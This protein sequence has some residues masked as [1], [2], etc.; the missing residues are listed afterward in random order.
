MQIVGDLSPG[1]RVFVA[2]LWIS[3]SAILRN[4]SLKGYQVCGLSHN[5]KDMG[6]RSR[7]GCK[8]VCP[9]PMTEPEA[10]VGAVSWL[11]DQCEEKPFIIPTSDHYVAALDREAPRLADKLLYY[12]F[13]DGALDD[14]GSGNG[15]HGRL[16]SKR[17]T[18]E[19]AE[20]HGLA[21]PATVPVESAEQLRRF[22]RRM[23]APV[24][25]KPEHS[26]D[27]WTP[28][29]RSILG[30][31]KAVVAESERE[32]IELYDRVGPVSERL[33]AQEVIPGP[34]SN[35]IY[36]AG[37][38]A[39]DGTLRG[40]L[41]GRKLRV[42]P[43]HLGSGT[44]VKLV[45][46]PEVEKRCE[47]FL[48]A[49]GYRGLCGIEFKIDPR[50]GIAKLIEVNPRYGLWEDIG[51]PAGV[52]LAEEAL[53]SALGRETQPHRPR[54]FR[55]K[56]MHFKSDLAVSFDY[57]AEGLLGPLAWLGSFATPLTVCDLPL[58]SDWPLARHNLASMFAIAMRRLG[59]TALG[60][61][62]KADIKVPNPRKSS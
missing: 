53:L 55:R 1:T 49:L 62:A 29:A 56:W 10:W 14:C 33:I 3:G 25:L 30:H 43:I 38:M 35:L 28:R 27:W 15:L 18:F 20:R 44:F 60:S 36:W 8:A 11:A 46:M 34:D 13:G 40:R 12:G 23:K 19:L 41:V 52:D 6:F 37:H 31:S 4:L 39:A 16:T 32:L 22:W 48:A 24:L 5:I 45:D 59:V 21:M 51:V 50:D 57:G 26:T 61:G 54:E 47:D 42:R 2:G 17:I 7:H 58:V 9:D